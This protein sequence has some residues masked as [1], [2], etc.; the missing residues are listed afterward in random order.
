MSDYEL[1]FKAAISEVMRMFSAEHTWYQ[2]LWESNVESDVLHRQEV[3][4]RMLHEVISRLE[5][6]HQ[7]R[8]GR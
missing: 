1:G 2:E 7:I 8:K 4:L 3:R 5:Q 6:M